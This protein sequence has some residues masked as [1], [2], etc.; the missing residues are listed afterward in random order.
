MIA[1]SGSTSVSTVFERKTAS[2]TIHTVRIENSSSA[3]PDIE[4]WGVKAVT[5]VRRMEIS[6]DG[7]SLF[8]PRSVFADLLDPRLASVKFE[9]GDFVLVITGAD[10]AESYIVRVYFGATRVKRRRVY[11]SLTPESVAED[12]RYRRLTVLKDE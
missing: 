4:D 3:F 1:Q 10:G 7:K 2:V 11:S 5:I 6:V 12:T 9:K 8:I